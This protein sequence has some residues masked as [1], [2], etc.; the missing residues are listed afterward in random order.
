M[1]LSLYWDQ[2]KRWQTVTTLK[3]ERNQDNGAGYFDYRTKAVKH[4]IAWTR[5]PWKVRLTGR[6]ARY[7][8]DVQTVGFG[9]NPP[10]RIKDELSAKAQIE[11]QLGP[12]WTAFTDYAWERLRSNDPLVSYRVNTVSVGGIGLELLT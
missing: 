10:H 6:A 8:Y 1:G 12:R 5:P 7:D 2:A 4:K 11:R 3:T 9:I